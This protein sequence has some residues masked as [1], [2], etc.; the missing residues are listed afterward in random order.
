MCNS[1]YV[2]A[3]NGNRRRRYAR[4]PERMAER[5]GAHLSEPLNDFSG[6]PRN[7]LKSKTP[8]NAPTL[9]LAGPLD[10]TFLTSEVPGVLNR[11]LQA[12]YVK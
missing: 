3:E 8:W 6:K 12:R 5:V 4:N 7:A 2:S 11:R 10:F 1:A 9:V